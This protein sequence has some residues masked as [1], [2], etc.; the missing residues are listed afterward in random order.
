MLTKG[1]FRLPGEAQKIDRLTQAFAIA[2][3]EDNRPTPQMLET[4]GIT[5][6]PPTPAGT[7][8]VSGMR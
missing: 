4:A 7:D 3:Y 1:G 6:P 2:F 8:C 5:L